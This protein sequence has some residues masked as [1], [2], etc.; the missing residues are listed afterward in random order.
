MM[1]V[2][3]QSDADRVSTI[4]EAFGGPVLIYVVETSYSYGKYWTFWNEYGS[5]DT[6]RHAVDRLKRV[7]LENF[8]ARIIKKEIIE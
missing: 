4:P 7:S 8:T 1:H 5:L 2:I 6:A 3:S